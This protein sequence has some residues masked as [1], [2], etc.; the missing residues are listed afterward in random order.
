MEILGLISAI[1][2]SIGFIY[3][4]IT[5]YTDRSWI[6]E[7]GLSIFIIGKSLIMLAWPARILVMLSTEHFKNIG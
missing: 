6:A 5:C 7:S 1:Y 3:A 2:L 4:L